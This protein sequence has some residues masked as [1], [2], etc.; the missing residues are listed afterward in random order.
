M[1]AIERHP[2]RVLAA[3][4]EEARSRLLAVAELRSYPQ[5]EVLIQQGDPIEFVYF[6]VSGVV[7][8][9][10]MADNGIAVE[11]AAVGRDGFVDARVNG[12]KVPAVMSSIYQVEGS[13][14]RVPAREFVRLQ[15]E[16]FA[17]RDVTIAFLQSFVAQTAQAVACNRLHTIP[18]RL[19][20]W[21]LGFHDRVDG[22]E[23]KLTHQFMAQ[24]LGVRRASVTVAAGD[25][26]RSGAIRHRRGHITVLDRDRL[27]EITCECYGI[28]RAE[29]DRRLPTS[30]GSGEI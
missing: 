28:I 27:D 9:V 15:H 18:Q 16:Q 14:L 13:A 5:R 1:E 25:L 4:S 17:L 24:M 6:P 7:S 21:L 23:F 20:R 29:I 19:A 11:V 26:E 22:D 3:L 30:E 2:N 8:V 12:D 10:V